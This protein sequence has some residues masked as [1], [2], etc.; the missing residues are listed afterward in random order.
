M[1]N[2]F[3]YSGG[4]ADGISA[5]QSALAPDGDYSFGEFG[6]DFRASVT[7]C[8][9]SSGSAAD[10]V[11]LGRGAAIFGSLDLGA[12]DMSGCSADF[13]RFFT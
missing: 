11:T 1:K 4:A 7:G 5:V 2:G 9:V 12:G 13:S 6:S 10:T 8:A 3:I